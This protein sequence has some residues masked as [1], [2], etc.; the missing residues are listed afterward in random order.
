MNDEKQWLGNWALIPNGFPDSD[1]LV[2]F[3]LD[4]YEA[5]PPLLADSLIREDYRNCELRALDKRMEKPLTD[6]CYSHFYE[7]NRNMY[8]FDI[9]WINDLQFTTYEGPDKDSKDEMKRLP[10]RYK[11]HQD[12][13]TNNE[14]TLPRPFNRKLSMSIQLSDS[15]DY[16]GGDFRF[17]QGINELPYEESREKGSILIFPSFYMHEVT[18]VTK[19]TRHALVTWIE[20]PK[21]R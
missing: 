2:E 18:P 7:A 15:D 4:H 20:G 17:E 12:V 13:E 1:T 9:E 21:W 8:N 14:G 3:V 10:G 19:G 6:L 11:M 16:E 5:I